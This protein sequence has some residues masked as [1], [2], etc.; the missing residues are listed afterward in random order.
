ML[1]LGVHVSIA[2][3]IYYSIERAKSLNCTAMQIF[4]RNPRQFLKSSLS[5][6]DIGIFR[7]KIKE[8][9]INPLVIH[10]PYTLNLAAAKD[11]LYR[12]TIREFTSDVKEAARLGAQFIVIHTGSFNGDEITGLN[13]IVGAL[14]IV[15]KDTAAA[16]TTILLENTAGE[17][18]V[19][20]CRMSHFGFI[21][22]KL[23]Q[24]KRVALC[25]DTAHAWAAG[26]GI[27]RESGLNNLLA[28]AKEE[29]GIEKIK[30]IHLNDTLYPLGSR[31]DRHFHVGRGKI[32]KDGFSLIVNHRQLRNLPFILETPKETDDDD[33]N[34]LSAVRRLY[35][36]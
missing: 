25:L 13:R 33:K 8:A 28:E 16:A 32:G 7:A 12:A 5:K 26:Y 24:T 6:E 1:K 15:L 23:K 29:V 9:K 3:K 27:N 22:S 21:F 10:T 18:H 19:L 36:G 14:K 34:N 2:G 30:L 31:K 20:G 17:G 11:F 35:K 4:S